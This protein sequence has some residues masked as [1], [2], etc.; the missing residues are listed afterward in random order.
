MLGAG[1][2][3]DSRFRVQIQLLV[4]CLNSGSGLLVPDSGSD[5]DSVLLNQF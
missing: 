4:Q 2:V 3:S 5:S 1:S